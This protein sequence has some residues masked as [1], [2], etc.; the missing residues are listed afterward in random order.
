MRSALSGM[1]VKHPGIAVPR[2]D[3][4]LTKNAAAA[5]LLTG[6]F[7]FVRAMPDLRSGRCGSGLLQRRVHRKTQFHPMASASLAEP[8][9]AVQPGR[10][11]IDQLPP[12][13]GLLAGPR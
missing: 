11:G 7:K 1:A 5:V 12:K 6:P 8:D 9:R 2:S 13:P 4:L 3:D 10:E